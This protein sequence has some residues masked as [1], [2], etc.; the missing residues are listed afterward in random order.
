MKD[1]EVDATSL[2]EA[3]RIWFDMDVVFQIDGKFY[4]FSTWAIYKK[5]RKANRLVK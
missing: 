2:E 1:Y 3:K 4:A 5:F